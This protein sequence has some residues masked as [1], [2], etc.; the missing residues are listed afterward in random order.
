MSDDE[1]ITQWITSLQ[2]GDEAAAEGLWSVFYE[3]LRRYAQ[4]KLGEIPKRVSDEEDVALSAFHA[5]VE[6]VKQDS[7][8]KMSS[9]DDFWQLLVVITARKAA[10]LH[11]KHRQRREAGESVLKGLDD[12]R[13]SSGHRSNDDAPPQQDLALYFHCTEVLEQ[14]PGNL[15]QVVLMRVAGYRNQEIAKRLGR[16]EKTIEH[17][18]RQVRAMWVELDPPDGQ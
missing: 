10:N 4:K 12:S 5:V 9:R 3:R 8:A 1:P 13:V 18:F 17:Y 14:L 11:R 2:S 6:G 15:R 16:S 7:F